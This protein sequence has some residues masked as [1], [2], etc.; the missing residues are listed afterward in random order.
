[1]RLIAFIVVLCLCSTR[2][3]AKPNFFKNML[4]KLHKA[5]KE[6]VGDKSERED[7]KPWFC[8]DL[9]CPEFKVVRNI[10]VNDDLVIEERCY[11]ET[12]W[13]Q[14]A[15]NGDRQNLKYYTMFQKLFAYIQ[16]DENVKKE[17]IEMTAPVLVS[18]TDINDETV[19]AQ[20]GFFVP[21]AEESTAPAPTRK[22]VKIGSK[23][24]MCVYVYSYG[25]WQMNLD[26]KFWKNVNIL[27][28]GLREAG[29]TDFDE[30]AGAM[31]A[32]YDSPFR[33]FNRHNEVMVLKKPSEEIKVENK[34]S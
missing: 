21:P 6:V 19:N 25:G 32:G 13:V 16:K 10:T 22:D 5:V 3:E 23:T 9:D 28:D 33:V 27:K 4:G 15:M 20:M 2:L 11:P 26:N 29:V 12:T 17:K 18:V 31:F 14:T 8:H 34:S 30:S 24:P 1:M 7:G